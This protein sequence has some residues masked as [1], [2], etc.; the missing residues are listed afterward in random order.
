LMIVEGGWSE[1]IKWKM[2]GR[3]LKASLCSTLA[4]EQ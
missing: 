1:K 2:P 3:T 4:Q